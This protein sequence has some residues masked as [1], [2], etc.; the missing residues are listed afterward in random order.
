[1]ERRRFPRVLPGMSPCRLCLAVLVVGVALGC[2]GK[3]EGASSTRAA[4]LHEAETH[5]RGGDYAG[6]MTILR[7]GLDAH[8]DDPERLNRFALAARLRHDATSEM[9]FR[10]QELLA[11]RRARAA[12]H[13]YPVPTALRVAILVN[14]STTLWEMGMRKEAAASYREALRWAPVH[15]DAAGIWRR[16]R[17]A[18]TLPEEDELDR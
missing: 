1:M 18:D 8:P 15:P 7:K 5:A 3:E 10:D 9:D 2:G 6:A 12:L 13:R 17:A 11:L 4:Q 16:I 14:L